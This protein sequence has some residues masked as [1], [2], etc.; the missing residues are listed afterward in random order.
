MAELQAFFHMGGYAWYVW[1]SFLISL[2][3]LMANVVHSRM[4]YKRVLRE[5][6]NRVEALAQKQP[7][8]ANSETTTKKM[9]S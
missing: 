3:V 2:V 6:A 7:R 9:I 4:Q 8:S 1:P 5:T